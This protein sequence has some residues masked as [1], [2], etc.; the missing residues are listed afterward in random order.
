MLGLEGS[1]LKRKLIGLAMIASSLGLILPALLM[2]SMDFME[3][4]KSMAR[5]LGIQAH[6]TGQNSASAL[7][8]NDP[9]F[10]GQTLKALEADP[11]IVAAAV[12]DA[13]GKVF[14]AYKHA[15]S[16]D[17]V[18][19]EK[20]DMVGIRYANGGL[21]AIEPIQKDNQAL[22]TTLGTILL[23]RGLRDFYARLVSNA[24]ILAVVILIT[25]ALVYLLASRL[26]RKIS[27]PV[28]DLAEVARKV[29]AEKNY[30]IRAKRG[31]GDEVGFLIDQFNVMM[32]QL[33]A[34]QKKLREVNEQL[35]YSEKKALAGSQAKGDFLAN[36]SHEIRTPMNA[37][38]GLTHLCQKTELNQRQRD[39]LKKIERASNS[40]LGII[41]DILDFSKIEAGRLEIESAPFNL[42]DVLNGLSNLIAP[43]AQEKNLEIL[44]R[45]AP[46]VPLNLLGDSLRLEQVLI[47]LCSNAVKFTQEG[48]IIVS[49]EL[50][51]AQGDLI[52]LLFSIKDTGIGMTP[53]QAARLFQPFTQADSS[54]TRKFGG[55]G[56]GLSISKRLVELM[57]GEIS[58]E[59]QPGKGS[60]F[61]F[62]AKF[63]PQAS[64]PPS[65][66]KASSNFRGLKVL[67]VD[68]NGTAREI[69]REMLESL[70]FSVDTAASGKEAL[71]RLAS[72]G[73]FNP[74]ALVLMDWK[75]PGLDG[76]EACRRIRA[77][78][79]I[80]P[81]P[82][83]I[84]ATAYGGEALAQQAELDG[85]E[86]L[87]VKPVNPSV[88]FDTIVAAFD[89]ETTFYTRTA[90]SQVAPQAP[91]ALRGLRFL[92]V[93]DNE[94]N[95]QVAEEL[96]RGAG[97]ET[98]VAS[99]GRE[100]LEKIGMR[101]FDGVL[102]DIQ[103]PEMDGYEAT[104]RLRADMRYRDM[105]IIAMT[106]NAMAGDRE[107]AI[108]AG[109]NDYVAKPIDPDELFKVL[110]Q[111]LGKGKGKG[112]D[113][114][115]A[116]NPM[117][118][119][120]AAVESV[121]NNEAA[122]RRV[123]GNVEILNKLLDSFRTQHA[124]AATELRAML[125]AQSWADAERAA[126]TLKS[127]AGNLGATPLA[128]NAGAIEYALRNGQRDNFDTMLAALETALA[129]VIELIPRS[130]R[131]VAI[132]GAEVRPDMNPTQMRALDPLL[133]K[134]EQLLKADDFASLQYLDEVA[135]HAQG[136]GWPEFLD[137]LRKN[138]NRYEFEKALDHLQQLRKREAGSLSQKE[139]AGA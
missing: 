18:L 33:D 131:T 2:G 102:M 127:I 31:S 105:V 51:A 130:S 103:M 129:A 61:R 98:T 97:V 82:K 15:G 11:R 23:H 47:N 72:H 70:S 137:S 121:L 106:A 4:R 19:P 14:A 77:A 40:L 68:D 80:E 133:D 123:G 104:R 25:A 113:P 65:K 128:R 71:E 139:S 96:L 52:E 55:T 42:E 46:N 88:L 22:G 87:L 34:H 85:L 37:I 58:L 69:F 29:S 112:I 20:P 116:P 108:E 138:V 17:F 122:L 1:S 30:T 73:P 101:H 48:E 91:A 120:P 60:C 89:S 84:L 92:L 57:K 132:D 125:N 16:E 99:N 95:Q 38:I 90:P 134:L 64:P 79:S 114:G 136:R 75:M 36:M 56:L 49:V 110:D 76:L 78:D 41:N 9:E 117:P 111:W 107:R 126:H 53:E 93:E 81:K 32:E 5:E 3:R 35:A 12:Y 54:T 124:G 50:G 86:G 24:A 62:S 59:S 115:D 74:Y 67:V 66:L 6:L 13:S 135:R 39:Y 8:F 21:E 28:L 44:F 10:V 109:M 7:A 119:P 27:E 43:K 100:A 26:Q 83:I 45:T 94:I 63:Q 118:P